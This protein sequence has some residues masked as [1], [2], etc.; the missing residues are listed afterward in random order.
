MFLEEYDYIVKEKRYIKDYELIDSF[1]LKLLLTK[2]IL[3]DLF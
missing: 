1:L 3:I 2:K